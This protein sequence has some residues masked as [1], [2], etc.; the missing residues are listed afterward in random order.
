MSGGGSAGAVSYPAY[1]QTFHNRYL[2][3]TG[4]TTIT[5][6]VA[7]AINAATSANP[8]T[9]KSS[10]DPT[11]SLTAMD[12]YLF[13]LDTIITA[14]AY[15]T[16]F[17]NAYALAAANFPL[18]VA[19][20]DTITVDTT[21]VAADVVA[22]DNELTDRLDNVIL[23]TFKVGMLNINAIQTSSFVLGEAVLRAFK[24]RDVA[25]HNSSLRLDLAKQ[26]DEL[27]TRFKL[28]RREL[29]YKFFLSRQ[30]NIKVVLAEILVLM[31]QKIAFSIDYTKVAIEAK[32]LN[33][34]A[35]TEQATEDAKYDEQEAKWPLDLFGYANSALGGIGGGGGGHVTPNKPSKAVSAL[36]GAASGAAAGAVTGAAIGAGGGPYGAAIGAVIGAGIAL[37][38]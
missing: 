9:G 10:F 5:N 30:E 23:P 31:K 16:D 28:Q 36:A 15:S 37:A 11:T 2:D 14:M 6:S 1:M 33:I 20:L 19:I 38:Q 27:N 26:N 22:F 12:S 21:Q 7:D 35:K 4:A 25:K 29:D 34:I 32:R 18:G 8:F 17:T 24:D 3:D 13:N